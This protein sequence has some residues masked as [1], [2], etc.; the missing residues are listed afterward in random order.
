MMGYHLAYGRF[1]DIKIESGEDCLYEI[2]KKQQ[3]MKNN[4]Y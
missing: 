2:L 1:T 4:L 3:N